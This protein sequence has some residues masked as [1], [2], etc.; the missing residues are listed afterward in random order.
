MGQPKVTSWKIGSVGKG[1]RSSKGG[2]PGKEWQF[3][4][5]TSVKMLAREEK[6]AVRGG[7]RRL[8]GE[9]VKRSHYVKGFSLQRA[10]KK[11]Q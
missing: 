2:R 1:R 3:N 11:I 8:K 10:D 5:K 9:S 4:L 7:R 6:W